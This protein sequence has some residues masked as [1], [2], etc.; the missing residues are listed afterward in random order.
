MPRRQCYFAISRRRH[1]NAI[2][3]HSLNHHRWHQMIRLGLIRIDHHQT[4]AR[5]EPD[6]AITAAHETRAI[7][8]I[9]LQ[10]R[11]RFF[12]TKEPRPDGFRFARERIF[13]LVLS[14]LKNSMIGTKPKTAAVILGHRA[15]ITVVQT[16]F[17]R[18]A[19][20]F[21]FV[22]PT[23]TRAGIANPQIA[24]RRHIQTA[25]RFAACQRTFGGIHD[26]VVFNAQ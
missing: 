3:P 16:A 18:E 25:H 10:T 4:A 12:A 14:H 19:R 11:Q 6:F 9:P 23:N 2:H 21:P 1:G 26:F 5:R 15:N 7:A 17:R 22:Q 13:Q 8:K 24:I 20:K